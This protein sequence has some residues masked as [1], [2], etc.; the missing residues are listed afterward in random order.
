MGLV[1]SASS[2]PSIPHGHARSAFRKVPAPRVATFH[3][4]KKLCS[5]KLFYV[6]LQFPL[7]SQLCVDAHAA[8]WAWWL[9]EEQVVE[10]LGLGRLWGVQHLQG[11]LLT[12]RA[13]AG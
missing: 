9:G 5:E 4:L 8:P 3:F 1:L 2:R 10:A 11:Q 13:E 7:P 6:G 12:A